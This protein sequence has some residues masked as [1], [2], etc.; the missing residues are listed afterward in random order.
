[1]TGLSHRTARA[2]F[3]RLL[4]TTRTQASAA[5][6]LILGAT[7]L[8]MACGWLSSLSAT[9]E[10]K[11]SVAAGPATPPCPGALVSFEWT[12]ASTRLPM[13]GTNDARITGHVQGDTLVLDA[14]LYRQMRGPTRDQPIQE[15]VTW[16]GSLTGD[17]VSV[18]LRLLPVSAR[19]VEP[20]GV[21]RP[22][23]RPPSAQLRT[24][25]TEGCSF[26]GEL[27]ESSALA[28]HIDRLVRKIRAEAPTTQRP[29]VVTVHVE[30]SATQA[31]LWCGTASPM[32][33]ALR[34]QEARFVGIPAGPCRL[35]LGD[36]AV[37]VLAEVISGDHIACAGIESPFVCHRVAAAPTAPEAAPGPSLP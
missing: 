37:E 35:G 4:P 21:S 24:D 15:E 16:T 29:S 1:M 17:E 30:G 9:P 23:R 10:P 31:T 11:P 33:L 22:R 19:E 18:W 7:S 32:R 20:P 3:G 26:T 14:H 28:T 36:P 6:A 25:Y 13:G 5:R 27:I 34:N 2:F 12:D 8:T